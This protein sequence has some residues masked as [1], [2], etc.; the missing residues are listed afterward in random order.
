[1]N[2]GRSDTRFR[3]LQD[4]RPRIIVRHLRNN[5][6]L[7]TFLVL[8]II[9]ALSSEFFATTN[10]LIIILT[11]LAPLGI[12]VIGQT[13]V[14]ITGGIDLSV[15]SVA[16]LT[17]VIAAKL[18]LLE[19]GLGL[20]PLVAIGIA[21]AAAT[22]IGWLQGWL[23]A[24]QEL[25]P[26][27]VTFGSLS[28]IKGVALVYSNAAPISIPRDLTHAVWGSSRPLPI[29]LLLVIALLAS[30]M[31]RNTK[32]GRYAFAIGSNETVTRM[33]G[34]RVDYYKIQ[35]YM[36]SSFLA[37]IAGILLMTRIGSGVYTNAEDYGLMS[38]AA[39]VIGGAS[40][41]G[42]VGNIQGPLLG[43]L[44][45]VMI[46]TSL[47]LSKVSPLWSTAIIGG[48]ILVAALAD[49]IRRRSQD[50]TPRTPSR[51]VQ[52]QTSYYAQ[53]RARLASLI[54]QRTACEH[55]RLYMLDRQ[56]GDLVEQ[57]LDS[58]ERVIVHQPGHL[59]KHVEQTRAPFWVDNWN[60]SAEPV[61]VPID[62]HLD[63]RSAIAVPI[64]VEQRFI[65]VLELQSPYEGVF[66]ERTA[67]QLTAL[68]Q[69]LARSLENAWL[70]DSGWLLR[71]TRDAF[72]HLWDEVS[73]GKGGLAGWL[74]SSPDVAQTPIATRGYRLQ[75]LLLKLMD[76]IQEK[77]T[78]SASGGK[79]RYQI[80]YDTYV[81][82]FSTEEMIDRLYVSRRQY[83]YDLKDALDAVAHLLIDE[84]VHGIMEQV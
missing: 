6:L 77:E 71:Q 64:L 76:I 68:T 12:V 59:A 5:A 26:F 42:G 44:I 39:A 53:I 16:A 13:L 47:G 1:M 23:I 73:L 22:A 49:R 46:D 80:L 28:L 81:Q 15:G 60:D 55:I 35:I 7:V 56:T 8:F 75:Q 69:E 19:D 11:Q 74:Y 41:H 38:V 48:F 79:S 51:R 34:V 10:N 62:P 31:L 57:N 33:S 52:S 70:L 2:E 65:G 18:M 58:E 36:M 66:N 54:T 4:E 29:L 72:R 25:P 32:M 37:G 24:R 20:P 83:F 63:C 43:T 21:L 3:W 27:I 67:S 50:E 45:I 40:L 30:Y 61:I 82:G 78:K 84:D 14:V 9:F 17:S